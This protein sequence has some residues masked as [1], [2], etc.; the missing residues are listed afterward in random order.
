MVFLGIS[1]VR[2]TIVMFTALL[3]L[4]CSV[5]R[6][7]VASAIATVT[8]TVE[9]SDGS[10]V[11]NATV[12]LIGSSIFTAQSDASGSFV[13]LSVPDGNYRVVVNAKGLG[14]ATR[15]RILVAGEVHVTVRYEPGGAGL[16]TIASVSVR[17]LSSINVTPAAIN[18]VTAQQIAAQ[19]SI[20]LSRVLSEIP[21][22]QI[23]MSEAGTSGAAFAD[24]YA[25]NSPANPI[26]IGIRG[27]QPYENA[28]LFDGHRI[29]SANCIIQSELAH[30]RIV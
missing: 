28:T 6:A 16:K 29:D 21:G 1:S 10:P 23:T 13:F 19:G 9:Q 15:E 8:G 27:S 22:V 5:S 7:Q 30:F 2:L 17:T 25:V 12:Q 14:Q 24:E 11:K 4:C 3:F 20:G 18:S 26:Y